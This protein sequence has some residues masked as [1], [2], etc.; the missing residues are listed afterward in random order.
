MN[1]ISEFVVPE[2]PLMVTVAGEPATVSRLTGL[3]VPIPT[4]PD[5]VNVVKAPVLAVADPMAPGEAQ[6]TW[7]FASVPT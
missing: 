4:L 5:V 7:A 6:F 3:V 2:V 1:Q